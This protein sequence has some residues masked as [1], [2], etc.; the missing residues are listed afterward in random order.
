MS[1]Y[2][3]AMFGEAER[4]EYRTAYFLQTL[5]QLAEYLGN[6]PPESKGLFYAVQ[7]LMFQR[8]LIFF[9][10][11]EEGYSYQD[12]LSGLHMLEKQKLI[13]NINAI[14]LPGVGDVEI[15]DATTPLCKQHHSILITSEPDLYDYLTEAKRSAD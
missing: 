2:T 12:Y 3:V 14:C 8:N 10:V 13:I 15:I 6:P 7:T 5:S 9:R 1:V 11:Q 4:G